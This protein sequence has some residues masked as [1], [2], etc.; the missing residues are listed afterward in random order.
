MQTS[1]RSSK[2]LLKMFFPSLRRKGLRI[3]GA[4]ACLVLGQPELLASLCQGPNPHSLGSWLPSPG[5][6]VLGLKHLLFPASVHPFP[7]KRELE[8]WRDREASP[9]TDTMMEIQ[10]CW[11]GARCKPEKI[12]V[13]RPQETGFLNNKTGKCRLVWDRKRVREKR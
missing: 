10:L 3:S 8:T 9:S 4:H 12:E 2:L 5:I 11:L 7:R 13:K 6:D 1:H